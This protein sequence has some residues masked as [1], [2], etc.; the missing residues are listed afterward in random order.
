VRAEVLQ[1]ADDCR[2]DKR[3]GGH[4][5]Q[6]AAMWVQAAGERRC[7]TRRSERRKNERST[8]GN[9]THGVVQY[10]FEQPM[11]RQRKRLTGAIEKRA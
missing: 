6:L 8:D 5:Q 10:A 2:R 4:E 1:R 11:I 7:P 9:S 3:P